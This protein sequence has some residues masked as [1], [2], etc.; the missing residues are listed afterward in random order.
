MYAP[1]LPHASSSAGRRTAAFAGL[2][3]LSALGGGLLAGCKDDPKLKVT[4]ILPSE[5]DAAGGTYV[6]IMGNRFTADGTRSAKIYFG[7]PGKGQ[8]GQFMR[9]ATDSEM[10][11]QAPGGKPG[12]VVD[13]LVI[14]EPGGELK[15]PK[16]FKFVDKSNAAPTVDDLTGAGAKPK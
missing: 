10:V 13:V 6:R 7:D 16:A 12:D 3:L 4:N 15:I 9:F 1:L 5:G 2:A 14:F 8:P 11:V